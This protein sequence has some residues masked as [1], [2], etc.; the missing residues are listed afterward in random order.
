MRFVFFL[1]HFVRLNHETGESQ[2]DRPL[3]TNT[4]S[5]NSSNKAS[6]KRMAMKLASTPKARNKDAAAKLWLVLA[7]RSTRVQ[8][9]GHWHEFYDPMTKETFYH[10]SNLD[11]YRWE[12]PMEFLSQD[13]TGES[14]GGENALLTPVVHHVDAI[15]TTSP[16]KSNQP[17]QVWEPVATP[18]G[19]HLYYWN[20]QTGEST[21]DKPVTD[22]KV[23]TSPDKK[24][25][26]SPATMAE[27]NQSSSMWS[28]LR[29]HAVVEYM[30]GDWECLLE[31]Q[32]NQRF[33][34]NKS[35]GKY[36]SEGASI[37]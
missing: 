1:L 10:N 37:A 3:E 28:E 12:V 20:N 16:S 11:E 2:W 36:L 15:N 30:H 35:T 27:L 23:K 22:S 19:K 6:P 25:L 8:V 31:H 13:G 7:Q 34:Y 9:N 5:S 18:K 26:T 33:Y 17:V 32:A 4:S 21:W 29:S 24:V 14:S